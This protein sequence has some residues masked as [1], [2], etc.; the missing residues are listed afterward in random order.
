MPNNYF[1]GDYI[2]LGYNHNNFFS[3]LDENEKSKNQAIAL[4]FAD[5][6]LSHSLNF[7]R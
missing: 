5:G 3:N 1:G 6:G 4:I 7:S 2:K